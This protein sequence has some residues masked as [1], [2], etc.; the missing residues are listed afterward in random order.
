M[1][2]RRIREELTQ[3]R[4]LLD[5][6]FQG[7]LAAVSET[8]PARIS[9]QSMRIRQYGMERLGKLL[10][11]LSGKLEGR[12]HTLSREGDEELF[13]LFCSIYRYLEEG[14]ILTGMDEAEERICRKDWEEEA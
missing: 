6:L 2:E 5:D 12:R 7:G 3:C 8:M 11:E 4:T 14:I 10:Q 13:D 1:K 9:K